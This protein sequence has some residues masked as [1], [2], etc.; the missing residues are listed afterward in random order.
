M[1]VGAT[2]RDI[3]QLILKVAMFPLVAGL[4]IGLAGSLAVSRVLAS[5]LVRVSPADPSSLVAAGFVLLAAAILGCW[6]PLRRALRLD[7]A[8]ALKGE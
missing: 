4:M 3:V 6:I 2:P 1:A 7:P 8:L 5:E